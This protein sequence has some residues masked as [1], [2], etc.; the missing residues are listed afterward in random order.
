M[1]GHDLLE[2]L[3]IIVSPSFFD[4][5]EEMAKLVFERLA[6]GFGFP[7]CSVLSPF[8]LQEAAAHWVKQHTEEN[9]TH[10]DADG[11]T[12]V[13]TIMAPEKVD[14]VITARAVATT[15]TTAGA[16]SSA[17]GHATASTT[18]SARKNSRSWT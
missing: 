12:A 11:A 8:A 2:G 4:L 16:A 10:H 6:C 13:I 15:I 7:W 18:T 14:A 9:H 5:V 1:R 3:L 17:A